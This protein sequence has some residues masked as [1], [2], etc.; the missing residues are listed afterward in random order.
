MY[1]LFNILV[2]STTEGVET[3][4]EMMGGLIHLELIFPL[5]KAYGESSTWGV[6][7]SNASAHSGLSARID[8]TL[9]ELPCAGCTLIFAGLGLT[10]IC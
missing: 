7:I 5:W 2:K 10:I 3:S 4:C 9:A 1:P 6:R 8:C